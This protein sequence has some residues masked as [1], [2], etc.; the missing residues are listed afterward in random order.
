MS[1]DTLELGFDLDA[2]MSSGGGKYR[3]YKTEYL[4][5][6]TAFYR[7]LPSFDPVDR[8]IN[9]EYYMHWLTG[10]NNKMMKVQCTKG[11]EGYCPLCE[12]SKQAETAAKSVEQNEGKDS[13]HYKQL[14]DTSEALRASRSVYFNAVNAAGE[15]VILELNATT[16]K[17][18][19]KKMEKAKELGFDPTHP[20]TGAWFRFSKNGKG[21]DAYEVDFK[22]VQVVID[23]ETL[24]KNDR[25]PLTDE[26]I[27]KLPTTVADLKNPDNLYIQV[28]TSKELADFLRGV[29]LKNKYQ[30]KAQPAAEMSSKGDQVA[31]AIAS[32][33]GA[34]EALGDQAVGAAINA[35]NT[36]SAAAEVERL[37]NLAKS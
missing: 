23:G 37:R 6:G 9:F 29:P 31:A 2:L 11:T 35:A 36:S 12:A 4:K 24:E 18:L 19:A 30:K 27:E 17:L 16:V 28:F 20:K 7:V 3:K 26:M 25:T 1:N 32:V 22:K 5:E 13:A 34:T 10:D 8:R 33:P 15:P 14:M 21:R